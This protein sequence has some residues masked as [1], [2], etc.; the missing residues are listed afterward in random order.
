MGGQRSV[1]LAWDHSRGPAGPQDRTEPRAKPG[2]RGPQRGEL[3]A[4]SRPRRGD[5][6]SHRPTRVLIHTRMPAQALS[7][8]H[9]PRTH[10]ST[11]LQCTYTHTHPGP[12]T[13]HRM[14]S[15]ERC[16]N[17]NLLPALTSLLHPSRSLPGKGQSSGER[18]AEGRGQK[19]EKLHQPAHLW[20]PSGSRTRSHLPAQEDVQ[21]GE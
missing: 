18:R 12:S 11:H 9:N 19:P 20:R 16:L 2:S 7:L 14:C 1:I 3:W 17:R 8:L 15:P 10:S 4:R 21:A 13:T 5:T 6:D